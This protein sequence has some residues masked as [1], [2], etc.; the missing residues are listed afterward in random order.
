MTKGMDLDGNHKM[1]WFFDQ[2]VYSTSMPQYTFHAT[3]SFTADGK[4]TVV[5]QLT[6]TGVPDNWKVDLP[7][8]AHISEEIVGLGSI[9]GN[10]SYRISKCFTA[11][12]V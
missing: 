6:R 12:K 10:A 7:L 11:R 9:A 2:Y 8:Y 5:A 4:T 3:L 1:D